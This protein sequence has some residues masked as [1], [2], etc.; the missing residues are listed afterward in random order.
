MANTQILTSIGDVSTTEPKVTGTTVGAD[1]GL[2]VNVIG[3]SIT[4]AIGGSPL[5]DINWDAYSFTSGATTD[6]WVFK[7]G[8]LGGTTVA[9]FVQTYTDSTKATVSNGVWS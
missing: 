3:G 7:S 1:H 9:T 5:G 4:V 2:D 8:G 6:T